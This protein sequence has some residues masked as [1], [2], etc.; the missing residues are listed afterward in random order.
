MKMTICSFSLFPLL[1]SL[2]FALDFYVGDL[3]SPQGP[4]GYSFKKP[5]KVMVDDFIFSALS[6]P[7]KHLEP[8]QSL[9][10]SCIR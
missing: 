5:M 7:G 4:A 8:H 3:N 2:S 1:F 9:H 10:N 6:H